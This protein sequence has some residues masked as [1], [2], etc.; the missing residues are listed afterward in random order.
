VA[1]EGGVLIVQTINIKTNWR[2]YCVIFII[3]VLLGAG[4]A[5]YIL[6]HN[7]GKRISD[8]NS[9]LR[10]AQDRSTKLSD[11]LRA[12]RENATAIKAIATGL[13]TENKRLIAE[14][15]ELGK[16]LANVRAGVVVAQG[17][18]SD[19]ISILQGIHERGKFKVVESKD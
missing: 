15:N 12:E 7:D 11:Q 8:I 17:R 14:N 18:N 13:S 9:Q 1:E 10:T 6:L 16:Q 3:G 4:I 5:G 2:A 19:N